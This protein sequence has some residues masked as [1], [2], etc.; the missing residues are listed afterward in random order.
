M[1]KTRVDAWGGNREA[2]GV[3][4][5]VIFVCLASVRDVYLGGLFQRLSPVD[6]AVVAFVLCSVVFFPIALA[7]SPESLRVLCHRRRDLVWINL[8]SALAWIG[9]FYALRTLEPLLAQILFSGVGPLS[10][11]WIDRLVT[12]AP[13]TTSI[14]RLERPVHLGLLAALTLAGAV[15]LGGL[16]GAEGQPLG[17]AALGVALA[18]GAGLSI[19]ANTVLCRRLNDAGVDPAALVAVRFPGAV[20]LAAALAVPS[21]HDFS[22]LFSTSAITA[23]LGASLLLIVFPI[24]V[25]QVGISLASPLTVRVVLASGPALIFLLQILEGRLSSSPYSLASAVLY[26]VFAVSAAL[27]RGAAQARG[28]GEARAAR[29][30]LAQ[31]SSSV[32]T[33]A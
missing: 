28:R 1:F 2:A 12:G 5:S 9:F 32:G 20:V 26:A 11:V 16:S 31:G 23:V 8:T 4:A 25:N 22:G 30:A 29:V 14:S 10:V 3:L 27:T 33:G 18:T 6:V 21:G 19:S 7:K 17:L 24:Y 15:A 13:S